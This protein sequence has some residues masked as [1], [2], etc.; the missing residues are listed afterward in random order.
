[1]YVSAEVLGVRLGDR[2]VFAA[3]RLGERLGERV[4]DGAV[5]AAHVHAQTLWE[6]GDEHADLGGGVFTTVVALGA[7]AR[8][9]A[10]R[11]T[12]WWSQ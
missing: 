4:S 2:G 8:L 7:A 1:M 10:R 3:E 5:A 12:S 6:G 9:A 11:L